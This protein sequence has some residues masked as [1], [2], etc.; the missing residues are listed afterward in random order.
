[1][2]INQ[3][4]KSS[5]MNKSELSKIVETNL[6]KEFGSIKAAADKMLKEA[7]KSQMQFSERNYTGLVVRRMFNRPSV[8]Y[9]FSV[10]IKGIGVTKTFGISMEY[11]NRQTAFDR[12][13]CLFN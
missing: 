1:M 8:K 3:Q 4:L 12:E 5:S 11:V 2:K 7:K 9:S 13:S 10:S 6:V